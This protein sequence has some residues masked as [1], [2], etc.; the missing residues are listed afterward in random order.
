MELR[1]Q[2]RGGQQTAVQTQRD[3]WNSKW[4]DY[5]NND[6]EGGQEEMR[7]MH[8]RIR[9]LKDQK[10]EKASDGSLKPFSA[11]NLQALE[12]L[13]AEWAFTLKYFRWPCS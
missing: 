10:K 12:Q 6:R 3:L 4:N 7:Q 13:M 1:S 11:P 2:S 8:G 5:H 9:S